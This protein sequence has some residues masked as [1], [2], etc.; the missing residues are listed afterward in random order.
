MTDSDLMIMP[1]EISVLPDRQAISFWTRRRSAS[2]EREGII[3]QLTTRTII[4]RIPS[5]G[6]T[7]AITW[8]ADGWG[9]FS[10]IAVEGAAI[11]IVES[12][13][14]SV[15]RKYKMA[16]GITDVRWLSPTHIAFIQLSG[17]DQATSAYLIPCDLGVLDISTGTVEM[18]TD[19]HDVSMPMGMVNGELWYV[20]KTE[21]STRLFSTSTSQPI[22]SA[23]PGR[24]MYTIADICGSGRILV[25]V[26]DPRIL[27]AIWSML[28][29]PF[30]T[31]RILPALRERAV[32]P[33]R[34]LIYDA[35]AGANVWSSK[36]GHVLWGNLSDDGHFALSVRLGSKRYGLAEHDRKGVEKIVAVVDAPLSIVGRIAD[37]WLAVFDYRT[38]CLVGSH[39][40]ERI[41][42]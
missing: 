14:L 19:S 30:R 33:L 4:G 37:A 17:A 15:R 1:D 25:L 36:P 13:T 41:Y 27:S 16:S 32:V 21:E 18:L 35:M 9:A 24:C 40:I 2:G 29:H 3:L 22:W 20:T 10:Q 11:A 23:P 31:P 26:E 28:K 6:L 5:S 34:A 12:S 38:L 7:S 8:N 42:P 39:G